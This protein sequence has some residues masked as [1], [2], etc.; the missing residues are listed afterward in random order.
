MKKA[1]TLLELVVVVIIIGVL[2]TLGIQQYGRAIEKSRGAE[3][4]QILGQIRSTAAA[5][6]LENNNSCIGF[7]NTRAGIGAQTDQ[8][9]SA[10]RPTHYFSYAITSANSNQIVATATRCTAGGKL[11]QAQSAYTLILTTNFETGTASW[12][13]TG[14][15]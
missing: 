2:A 7:T 10:C 8:I 13:G 1:F 6:R 14:G 15:Y 3:A 4:K 12:T 5:Y 9:P 11:P